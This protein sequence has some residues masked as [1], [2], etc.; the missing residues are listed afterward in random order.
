MY[1]NVLS[2]KIILQ[3]MC[4]NFFA[5]KKVRNFDCPYCSKRA[6][7]CTDCS[8]SSQVNQ[9]L[10]LLSSNCIYGHGDGL[11]N[12]VN[13]KKCNWGHQQIFAQREELK[14]EIQYSRVQEIIKFFQ[15]L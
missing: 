2:S 7:N 12:T 8:S 1:S 5:T 9:P 3:R 14:R 6:E 13:R 10:Q 15:Q 11:S 4:I